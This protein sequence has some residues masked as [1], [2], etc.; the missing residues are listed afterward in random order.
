MS[1]PASM[2]MPRE[3]DVDV[4]GRPWQLHRGATV[5]THAVAFSVWAPA[6]TS[7]SVHIATGDAAGDHPLAKS[8]TERGVWTAT[9]EAR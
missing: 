4:E 3:G 7:M 5:H 6:A 2:D 9:S 8:D 1:Y